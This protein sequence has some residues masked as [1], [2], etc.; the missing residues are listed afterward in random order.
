MRKAALSG[1]AMNVIIGLVSALIALI[2]LWAFHEKIFSFFSDTLLPGILNMLWHG[3]I[4][5]FKN[6]FGTII[7]T[8]GIVLSGF[9]SGGVGWFVGGS[10]IAAGVGFGAPAIFC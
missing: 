2:I 1:A 8:I 7:T 5:K 3:I 9:L 6:I 10:A 4:C